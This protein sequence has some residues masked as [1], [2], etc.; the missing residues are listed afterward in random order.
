MP[1]KSLRILTVDAQYEDDG[2]VERATAGDGYD[3]EIWRRREGVVVSNESFAAADALLVWHQLVVDADVIAK[4]KRC[5]FISRAGVGYDHIDLEAAGAR[6]IP[7]C[8]VPDYGT[9]EVADHAIALWLALRRG[10]VN[11]NEQLREDVIANFHWSNAKTIRRV[12]GTRFGIVGLGR[13]GTATALRAKAF[14]CE[15]VA[16]DPYL[17]RGQ[18][19]AVGVRRAESLENLLS[20][21]DCVSLHVPLTAE[22]RNMINV[23]TL[24]CIQPHAVLVNTSRGAVIDLDALYETLR[25]GK[26]AGVGLDVLPQEPPDPQHPLFQAYHQQLDWVLGRLVLTPHGA[27]YS[28]ESQHDA[29]RLAVENIISFFERGELRNCVN[30]EYLRGTT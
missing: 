4:L 8:Y 11:Y 10:I 13:I 25:A 5:R 26:I 6:G 20:E 15:V 16:Y 28:A 23:S 2:V 14:G 18:E 27:W 22:T 9:S 19:I 24:A 17:P 1:P 29:R 7:V 12:R 30:K 3:F 21:C